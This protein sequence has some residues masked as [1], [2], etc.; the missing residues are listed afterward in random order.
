MRM[1]VILYY[2]LKRYKHY[3]I[4]KPHI[5]QTNQLL[6][7]ILYLYILINFTLSKKLTKFINKTQWQSIRNVLSHPG[8]T[9]EMKNKINYLFFILKI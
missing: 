3:I 8:T 1:F 6:F 9:F 5:M 4:I 2:G 7:L